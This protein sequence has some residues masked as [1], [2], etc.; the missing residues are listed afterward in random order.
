MLAALV[1]LAGCSESDKGSGNNNTWTGTLTAKVDGVVTNF[2]DG[3][4]LEEINGGDAWV[5]GDAGS[6]QLQFYVAAALAGTYSTDSDGMGRYVPDTGVPNYDY[7]NPAGE[8]RSMPG[9]L[10]GW[11]TIATATA[12]RLAGSFAFQVATPS[13]SDTV[14]ITEGV[15][16]L[17]F[18]PPG[19]ADSPVG[20]WQRTVTGVEQETV[21]FLSGGGCN[22]VHA[23][24]QL[25]SCVQSSGTWSLVGDS[26]RLDLEGGPSTYAWSV[27]GNVLSVWDGAHPTP[28]TYLPAN[29][30]PACAD[31]GFGGNE[32]G[33]TGTLS[34]TVDGVPTDFS[35]VLWLETIAGGDA[36]VIGNAGDWQLQFYVA[37]AAP[38]SYPANPSSSA[39]MG[40]F[41]PDTSVPN[42]DYSNPAG[43]YN[44]NFAGAGGSITVT[45]ASPT[46][47]AGTFFFEVRNG[48]GDTVTISEGVVDMHAVTATTPA[49]IWQTGLEGDFEET[50]AFGEGGSFARVAADWTA[51]ACEAQ[52]NVWSHSAT[53]LFLGTGL[54][55]VPL[56]SW[57]L[58][59]GLLTIDYG[60]GTS[61]TYHPVAALPSCEDYVFDPL[62]ALYG[63]WERGSAGNFEETTAILPNHQFQ[64]TVALLAD[65][66][67]F[68]V[69]GVWALDGDSL[70][71]DYLDGDGPPAFHWSISGI[72][73]VLRAP[74]HMNMVFNRVASMPDCGDYGF[75]D[76]PPVGVWQQSEP[77]FFEYTL[78][79]AATSDFGLTYAHFADE[80]CFEEAGT[81]TATADTLHILFETWQEDLAYVR[82]GNA[83]H[84][85]FPD[86]FSTLLTR[87]EGMPTCAD[88]GMGGSPP[89]RDPRDQS[90]SRSAT[91]PPAFRGGSAF[92]LR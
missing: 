34:A 79:F 20:I 62:Q 77:E 3:L 54:N 36:W 66:I 87:T 19:Q 84:I 49:G 47:L 43:E 7:A 75:E 53:H 26:L 52:S 29:S 70:R 21:Q 51:G 92:R 12:N 23:N 48:A 4:R 25:E 63:Y 11:I 78:E 50:L 61:R 58:G 64:V 73:L 30:L 31:Y 5:I 67:C 45:A 81:W 6:T 28:R 60:N 14:S 57:S 38:G 15:F 74:G 41:V 13:L 27:Q 22:L 65:E 42:Y 88:Y 80:W 68:V 89:A 72:N 71:V 18:G 39:G 33:W 8:L 85:T 90:L 24:Y 56:G 37:T 91:D 2:S 1:A 86:G 59:T 83:L 44:T 17:R 40:R 46:S 69:N 16:D 76:G 32:T 10:G 9:V 55:R 82:T 35:E